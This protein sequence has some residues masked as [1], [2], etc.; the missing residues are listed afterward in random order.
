MS[1][2]FTDEQRKKYVAQ[3]GINCPEC[4]SS[5]IEGGHIE[6]DAGGAHQEIICKACGISYTDLYRLVDVE[7]S[8]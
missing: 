5:N 3:S 8:E 1:N 7:R 2:N 4:G 6:V